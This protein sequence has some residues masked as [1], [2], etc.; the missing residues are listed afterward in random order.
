MF[1]S[2]KRPY[3]KAKPTDTINKIKGILEEMGLNPE[4]TFT[5]NPYP[6]IYSMRLELPKEFGCFGTNGKGRSKEYSTA[7]GYAEFLER[8]QNNVFGTF[9]RTMIK[10]INNRHGFY[11]A[12][13]E[14]YLTKKE[15][16]QLPQKI[17]EDMVMYKNEGKEKFIDTYFNQLAKNEIPG[18]VSIP[19]YDTKNKELVYIPWNMIMMTLGSNGMAA[20]N[21]K[22]EAVFQGLCELMERW[23]SAEIFYNQITPPTIPDKF[24]KQFKEEYDIIQ[25]IQ[26]DGKYKVIVKDFSANKR[27]P[28]LGVII[29]NQEE[30]KYKLNVGSDT[31]FQSGLS[32]CLTEIYQGIKNTEKFQ[33]CMIDLP[34]EKPQYFENNTREARNLRYT[35]FSDFTANN[36]GVFP[37]SLFNEEFD[38][39]FDESV[40]TCRTSYDEEVKV[41]VD[42]LHK[43]GHNV[44]IRDNSYLGF[45]AVIVYI[46]EV[47][48]LGRKINTVINPINRFNVFE[49]DKIEDLILNFENSSEEDMKQ[50][51]KTLS[52][53]DFEIP[54]ERLFNVDLVNERNRCKINIQF[55]LT[56]L[57]YRL[58][59]YD[60]A[61]ESLRKFRETGTSNDEYYAVAEDYMNLKNSKLS[62][63]EIFQKLNQKG[64]RKNLVSE[65]CEDL[66]EPKEIFKY[67]PLPKCPNCDSCR[68]TDECLTKGKLK[69]CNKLYSKMKENPID[70]R[71][72]KKL[73]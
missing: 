67:T 11:Y 7:S 9:S 46:P 58:G 15:L 30:K 73:F 20:G 32:R 33:E 53:M 23:G 56:L 2:L 44:Y 61:I 62:G 24:L 72:I 38:Y 1:N 68:I 64:Y 19:F 47:S 55:F 22:S 29:I 41:M 69:V 3:K 54:F 66:E 50:I 40:F 37:P 52:D 14:K 63:K 48:A 5:A 13:D 65:V 16:M 57:R 35:V 71:E 36:S 4:E 26:R 45:P 12:P 8:I 34:Q 43:N 51:E 25:N 10:E 42:N 6:Q 31:A 21:T 70:Q 17:L 27:I 39:S 18:V 60:R 28:A 49:L 59:E